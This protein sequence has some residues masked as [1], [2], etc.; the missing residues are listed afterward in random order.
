MSAVRE[1]KSIP[2]TAGFTRCR[3]VSMSSSRGHQSSSGSL[4]GA[5]GDGESPVWGLRGTPGHVDTDG[6]RWFAMVKDAGKGVDLVETVDDIYG[7]VCRVR[8]MTADIRF[9]TR[10]WRNHND[11]VLLFS[12]L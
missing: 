1:G 2:R 7:V 11:I 3:P 6:S 9:H 4:L 12:G 8:S 10:L 5:I